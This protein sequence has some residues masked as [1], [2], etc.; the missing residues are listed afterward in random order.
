MLHFGQN[1]SLQKALHKWYVLL[2]IQ[3]IGE[4]PWAM[5]SI[6]HTK[7]K[8][9][10]LVGNFNYRVNNHFVHETAVLQSTVSTTSSGNLT[11]IW[12]GIG[13]VDVYSK[14]P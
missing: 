6:S 14:L 12:V 9:V 8:L 13:L 10:F 2:S 5:V 4:V 11:G 3:K 1:H 7:K